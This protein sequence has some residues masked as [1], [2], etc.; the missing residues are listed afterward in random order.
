MAQHFPILWHCSYDPTNSY[1]EFIRFLYWT[2]SALPAIEMKYYALP[3]KS[4]GDVM[5]AYTEECGKTQGA[6]FG[7]AGGP[8][9]HKFE[10]V[11]SLPHP[12]ILIFS[13]AWMISEARVL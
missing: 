10:M 1:S 12:F 5:K 13:K 9:A 7:I 4:F 3:Y 11:Y 8:V 2:L 6:G